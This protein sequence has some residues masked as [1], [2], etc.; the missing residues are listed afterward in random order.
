MKEFSLSTLNET[1]LFGAAACVFLAFGIARLAGELSA[2]V[3][4]RFPLGGKRGQR[5]A[6]ACRSVLFR[7][8]CPVL[9]WGGALVR[10]VFRRARNRGGTARRLSERWEAAQRKLLVRAG[11]PLGLD[12]YEAIFLSGLLALLGG[13]LALFFSEDTLLWVLP[14][15]LVGG[16]MLNLRLQALAL[17]RF[18]EVSREL[19]AAIDLA[20]LAMNAGTDFVGAVERVIEGQTGV[21]ADELGQVLSALQLGI[22]R[23]TALLALS[24]RVPTSD[25]RDLVRAIT[26]AEQ[27]GASISGALA[28]QATVSR[29]RRSVRAEEAAARAG[30][31]LLVPLMLLMAAI[32]IVLVGP[33]LSGGMGL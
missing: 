3:P 22:T 11:E 21:V 14:G 17:E 4:L 33:L 29:Q 2:L 18:N 30:V 1:A 16:W 24:E 9:R 27:K 23:R 19:P 7:A 20:A 15:A 28:Q 12:R 5:R 13:G 25:V 6:L 32:L 26:A 31:L 10:A 8:V